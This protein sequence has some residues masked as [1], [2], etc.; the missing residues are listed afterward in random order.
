MRGL[1][2]DKTVDLVVRNARTLEEAG[3][4]DI[5][6]EGSRI[7]SVKRTFKGKGRREIDAKGH[8]VLPTFIEPH[9]HLDKALLAERLPE[10][11]TIQEAREKVREAKESFTVDDIVKRAKTVLGWALASGVTHVRSH[12]DVDNIVRLTGIEALTKVRKDFRGLVELQLVA[13]PQEGIVKSPGVSKLLEEAVDR[14]ADVVGGLPETEPTLEWQRLHIQTVLRI[15]RAKNV[16]VYVHCDVGPST[17]TVKEFAAEVVKNGFQ[18]RTTADHLIS[19]SYFEDAKAA[20]IIALIK[21]AGINV[22]ANPCTMMVSGAAP[23]PPMGRGVT[24]IKEIIRA[25][26]NFSYGLD[27]I[28][29]PYNPFGDFDP[30]RNG[31]LLAYQGQ[32][33]SEDDMRSILEMNTYNAARTLRIPRYG[34]RPG[35]DAD[36][37]VLDAKSPRDALRQKTLSLFVIKKGRILVENK[38][39]KKSSIR[40]LRAG[41]P[42]FHES[43]LLAPQ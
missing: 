8:L 11:S 10:S 20:E 14:G 1:R 4:V 16:D 42:S 40:L 18:G 29:D 3:P 36:L 13:F 32:L 12:V 27:N 7:V 34:T 25:G 19:L 17:E 39:T 31:W 9:V 24:R 23:A 41:E 28:I 26:I 22:V 6:I 5:A 38:V 33:N 35:C 37:N 15:A 30:L 21:M 2:L 43:S